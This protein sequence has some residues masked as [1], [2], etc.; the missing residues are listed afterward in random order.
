M[1]SITLIFWKWGKLTTC[2]FSYGLVVLFINIFFFT[3]SLIYFCLF[4]HNLFP[5]FSPYCWVASDKWWLTDEPSCL[6]MWK[7]KMELLCI[8]HIQIYLTKNIT[9]KKWQLLLNF[10]TEISIWN[11]YF[12]HFAGYTKMVKTWYLWLYLGRVM[13]VYTFSMKQVP[14]CHCNY[15][16]LTGLPWW[17]WRELHT[18]RATSEITATDTLFNEENPFSSRYL[19]SDFIRR[20][21]YWIVSP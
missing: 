10:L 3:L 16:T 19:I 21:G 1:R 15:A 9:L 12:R 2:P 4:L 7:Q 11:T 6:W 5:Y 18:R 8:F 14:P 13:L 17:Y 20:I